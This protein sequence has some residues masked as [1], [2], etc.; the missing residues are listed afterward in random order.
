MY[1]FVRF[2]AK[3][4][5]K[6]TDWFL[7]VKD[8]ATLN[9]HTKRVFTP[10]MQEGLN[11]CLRRW[12]DAIFK[13][14]GIMMQHS[15]NAVAQTIENITRMQYEPGAMAFH[16]VANQMMV[17]AITG[18]G[19]DIMNGKTLYLSNGVVCYL[20][21]P[22]LAEIADTEENDRLVY[23]GYKKPTI[24]DVKFI[25]WENGTHWYA[26]LGGIDIV[27]KEGNQKW[28]SKAEAE[29]VVKEWLKNY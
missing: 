15:T 9:E 24:D 21:S 12:T 28:N 17:E 22:E 8:M 20:F 13:Y 27:D 11:D 1:K 10:T 5:G 26:K 23:P 7:E 4:T 25:Q 2:R 14:K 16:Q 19:Q 3:N 6:L 18:R 29:R